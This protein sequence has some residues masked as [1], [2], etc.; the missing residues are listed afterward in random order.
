MLDIEEILNGTKSFLEKKLKAVRIPFSGLN[1]TSPAS[2]CQLISVVP[3]M[4]LKNLGVSIAFK[5]LPLQLVEIKDRPL[6]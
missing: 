5:Q 1:Q 3:R 2:N 4:F 6:L